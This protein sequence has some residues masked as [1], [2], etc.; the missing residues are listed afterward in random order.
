MQTFKKKGTTAGAAAQAAEAR[1]RTANDQKCTELGWSCV[2][3]AVESY[4]AWGRSHRGK[5]CRII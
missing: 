4:G 5:K 3:L 1:K 2:P